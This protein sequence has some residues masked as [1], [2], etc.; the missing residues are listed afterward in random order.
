MAL[1][2]QKLTNENILNNN[3]AYFMYQKHEFDLL[4]LKPHIIVFDLFLALTCAAFNE[5]SGSYSCKS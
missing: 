5:R 4:L 3:F 2:G 1:K